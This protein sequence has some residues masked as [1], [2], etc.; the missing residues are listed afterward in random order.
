MPLYEYRCEGCNRTVELLRT[1][2]E[3]D[4]PV[5]CPKCNGRMKRMFSVAGAI[6]TGTGRTPGSTCCGR[7][8]RCESPPC[9]DGSCVR[10]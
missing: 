1:V 7:V 6:K 10:D 2:K 9:S 3:L 4:A 8:E 5:R